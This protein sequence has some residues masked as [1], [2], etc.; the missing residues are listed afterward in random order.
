METPWV[1]PPSDF[2]GRLPAHSR[3]SLLAR[4]RRAV[5]RKNDVVFQMGSPGT[6]VYILMSGRVK[7]SA[8]SPAGRSVILW[9]CFPGE[10]FGL[11]EM[12]RADRRRVTA[13]A[14]AESEA[15]VVPQ[16]QFKTFLQHDSDAA[17]FVIDLLS[18]RLRGLADMLINLTSD[19]VTTRLVKLLIRLN[20]RYGKSL[21]AAET[22]VDIHLTH[23]EI[24]DMIGTSRQ[25]ASTAINA[26]KRQGLLSMKK[27][28][29]H[30]QNSKLLENLARKLLPGA[31]MA[32]GA[33]TLSFMRQ[34]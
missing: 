2:L 22:L 31:A 4:G 27:Q 15:L 23:Q 26:L 19:D 30:I 8:L 33:S 29:I 34:V 6:N 21:S 11:A 13:E 10:I 17:M 3:D 5:Y 14:C 1:V 18:C 7:I 12:T 32:R 20:A 25:S 16:Q 24:A 28:C 9:F